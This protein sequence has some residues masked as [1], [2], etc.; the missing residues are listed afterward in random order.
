MPTEYPNGRVIV[1]ITPQQQLSESLVAT[2]QAALDAL[3]V[4]IEN[5]PDEVCAETWN[6]LKTG[7]TEGIEADIFLY[8]DGSGGEFVSNIKLHV[9]ETGSPF[10]KIGDVWYEFVEGGTAPS[11]AI[12]ELPNFIF[13]WTDEAG[14]TLEELNEAYNNYVWKLCGDEGEL[15]FTESNPQVPLNSAID[16]LAGEDG[17]PIEGVW[18]LRDVAGEVS[19]LAPEQ[20]NIVQCA[21][22]P[23]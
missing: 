21:F 2:Q 12:Q 13:P 10:V 5:C 19:A 20:P 17:S 9:N 8:I 15:Q 16:N 23:E 22:I 18:I 7:I 14:I 6:D 1:D 3:Q 11:S 4:Q